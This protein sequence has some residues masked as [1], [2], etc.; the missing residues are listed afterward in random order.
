M[1]TLQYSIKVYILYTSQMAAANRISL[2][3]L[4]DAASAHNVWHT[5]GH[6]PQ[7]WLGAPIALKY[8]SLVG[9]LLPVSPTSHHHPPPSLTGHS[10]WR[11]PTPSRFQLELQASSGSSNLNVIW[12]CASESAP[13]FFQWLPICRLSLLAQQP[14]PQVQA[15]DQ[16]S[17]RSAEHQSPI[18]WQW[19]ARRWSCWRVAPA[20]HTIQ[21]SRCYDMG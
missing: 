4:A 2:N 8:Y 10:G 13:T 5:L 14:L 19:R 17:H 7:S 9:P 20:T 12:C 3:I 18:C 11:F 21:S 16:D 1:F 6:V 15:R